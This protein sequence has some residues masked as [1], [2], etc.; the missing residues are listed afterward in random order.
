MRDVPDHLKPTSGEI[1]DAGLLLSENS[2]F[3]KTVEHLR[4]RIASQWMAKATTAAQREVAWIQIQCLDDLVA[5]LKSFRDF[6]KPDDARLARV[7]NE[8]KTANPLLDV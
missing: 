6:N 1:H 3:N 8:R 5:E 2:A 7:G 4:R